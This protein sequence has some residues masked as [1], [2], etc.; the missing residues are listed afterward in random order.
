MTVSGG[1][2]RSVPVCN[3]SREQQAR[4]YSPQG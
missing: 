1:E 4:K 3:T 2:T